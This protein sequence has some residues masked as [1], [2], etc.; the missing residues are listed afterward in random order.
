[1]GMSSTYED[2]NIIWTPAGNPTLL[3]QEKAE[4][5]F[6]VEE[7]FWYISIIMEPKDFSTPHG[8]LTLGALEEMIDWEEKMREIVEWES[9]TTGAGLKI[10]RTEEGPSYQYKD[11]CD[12][13]EQ[14]YK[15]DV[16]DVNCA[17]RET[18]DGSLDCKTKKVTRVSTAIDPSLRFE[19]VLVQK[20]I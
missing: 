6:P 19:R 17:T 20:L 12:E 7:N 18:D 2:E 3:N 11:V 14:T 13:Y 4:E 8:V 9:T 10:E 16:P 15:Y 5:M 1:M